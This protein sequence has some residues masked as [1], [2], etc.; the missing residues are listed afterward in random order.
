MTIHQIKTRIKELRSNPDAHDPYTFAWCELEALTAKLAPKY[1]PD[2]WDEP[3]H[4]EASRNHKKRALR[5][6]R[7][8]VEVW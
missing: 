1:E 7:K 6:H 8:L 5:D 2:E 3:T 4:G